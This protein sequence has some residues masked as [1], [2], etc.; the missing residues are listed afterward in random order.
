MSGAVESRVGTVS[1]TDPTL[2]SRSHTSSMTRRWRPTKAPLSKHRTGFDQ[3]LLPAEKP[4]AFERRFTIDRYARR[5]VERG[6]GPSHPSLDKGSRY[7]AVR[8][9]R[10][11]NPSASQRGTERAGRPRSQWCEFP[12]DCLRTTSMNLCKA[13]SLFSSLH[14]AKK[15]ILMRRCSIS[16]S[17]TVL[18][19]VLGCRLDGERE[20]DSSRL[21]GPM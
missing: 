15:S 13:E 16:L 4:A 12:V 6:S 3:I 14:M 10:R 2:R 19:F 17:T 18:R 7:A 5:P 20:I 8:W 1:W 21:P 11:S 9:W